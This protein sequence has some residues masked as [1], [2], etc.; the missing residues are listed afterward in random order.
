MLMFHRR[1]DDY[2]HLYTLAT[3]GN[4]H[5]NMKLLQKCDRGLHC[6]HQQDKD[7]QFAISLKLKLAVD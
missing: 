6:G 2:G 5:W 4:I 1:T 7:G 3:F